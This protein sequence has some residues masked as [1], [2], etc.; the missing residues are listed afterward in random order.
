[1]IYD[2]NDGDFEGVWDE[3]RALRADLE[4]LKSWRAEI[5]PKAEAALAAEKNW[6]I[7]GRAS[8]SVVFG[9]DAGQVETLPVNLVEILAAGRTLDGTI[10][11]L[12]PRIAFRSAGKIVGEIPVTLWVVLDRLLEHYPRGGAWRAPSPGFPGPLPAPFP[13]DSHG[14]GNAGDRPAGSGE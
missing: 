11:P 1:M 10:V 2:E 8:G 6:R 13:S 9:N 14:P 3:L 12:G 5:G 7:R 4:R